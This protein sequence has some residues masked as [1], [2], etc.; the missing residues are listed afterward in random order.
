ML[1]FHKERERERKKSWNEAHIE[2]C[3]S[4]NL[5]SERNTGVSQQRSK[6]I[7]QSKFEG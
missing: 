7:D 6:K 1:V 2:L 3:D 5:K 4:F